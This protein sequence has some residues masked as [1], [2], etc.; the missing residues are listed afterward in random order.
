MFR[1]K[2]P[3]FERLIPGYMHII[4]K[5]LFKQNVVD[6]SQ[7]YTLSRLVK[8]NLI[9]KSFPYAKYATNVTLQQ[10]NRPS[11]NLRES[12]KHF[13]GKHKLYGYK[14]EVSV[15]PNGQAVGVSNHDPGSLSDI[16]IFQQRAAWHS[17][18]LS[19]SEKYH[20]IVDIGPMEEKHSEKWAVLTGKGYQ[21]I[22]G[23]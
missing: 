6:M 10:T 1:I 8:R 13:S 19:K 4:P 3:T 20:N 21:G 17:L 23:I 9:F 11:G 22:C 16:H 18:N 15:L 14:L 7:F 2:G 12:K 5:P